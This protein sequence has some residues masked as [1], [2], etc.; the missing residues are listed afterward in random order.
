MDLIKDLQEIAKMKSHSDL[1]CDRI[2]ALLQ[3]FKEKTDGELF[4]ELENIQTE[5]EKINNKLNAI[6]RDDLV[7]EMEIR[8]RGYKTKRSEKFSKFSNLDI[9]NELK[10]I[11]VI[12]NEYIVD[13]ER[14]KQQE[15]DIQKIIKRRINS[16]YLH[17]KT[18]DIVDE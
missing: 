2:D 4:E 6:I 14:L 1:W 12:Q 16:S 17:T 18:F 13:I 7:N 15:H 11:S 10:K 8:L 5:K 3:N 9:F